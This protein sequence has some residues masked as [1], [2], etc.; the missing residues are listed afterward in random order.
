MGKFVGQEVWIQFWEK[1]LSIGKLR[2]RRKV[3]TTKVHIG[4]QCAEGGKCAGGRQRTDRG[5][6]P[7]MDKS[8]ERENKACQKDENSTF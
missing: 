8:R 3:S 4:E 1:I 2:R 6:N 7:T 5:I